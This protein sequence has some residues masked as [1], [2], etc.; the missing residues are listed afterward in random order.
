MSRPGFTKHRKFLRLSA[1]L[2]SKP[3]ALGV[4]EFM[5]QSRGEELTD[6]L[7]DAVDIAMIC[8]WGGEPAIL[9]NALRDCGGRGEAGLIEETESG[10]GLYKVHDFWDHPPDYVKKRLKREMAREAEGTTLSE[11]RAAAGRKGAASSR[12][13]RI[14]SPANGGQTADVCYT[15]NSVAAQ[16]SGQLPANGGQTAAD[17]GQPSGK[18]LPSPPAPLPLPSLSA[19]TCA[20]PPGRV[21]E[22]ERDADGSQELGEAFGRMFNAHPNPGGDVKAQRAFWA[23]VRAGH[24][25]ADGEP[26]P[27]GV[28]PALTICEVEQ[29]FKLWLAS[30]QWKEGFAPHFAKYM[31]DGEYR[32][33]PTAL[34]MKQRRGKDTTINGMPIIPVKI[35]PPSIRMVQR[36]ASDLYREQF[37]SGT[38]DRQALDAYL[39][40]VNSIEDRQELYAI[41]DS[42]K[43]RPA[44]PGQTGKEA[45]H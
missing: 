22:R 44:P 18:S 40:K 15:D 41:I 37:K 21:N 31:E 29:N 3:L 16:T 24:I 27:P 13:H 23:E 43:A 34:A 1:A 20:Q 25:R 12:A 45:S 39:I 6:F 26:L 11:I 10:S 17:P 33:P 30:E 32:R 8:E 2:G 35:E 5:W 36:E 7:G 28:G 38:I 4:C 14:T 19:P 9:V 42:V